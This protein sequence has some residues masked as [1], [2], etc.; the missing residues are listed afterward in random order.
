ML[1]YVCRAVVLFSTGVLF[2]LVFRIHQIQHNYNFQPYS[3][4]ISSISHHLSAFWW[5]STACGIAAAIVGLLYPCVDKRFCQQSCNPFP[6]EWTTVLRCIAIY[7]GISHAITKLHFTSHGELIVTL[8]AM[9]AAL[10]WLCD[11]TKKGLGLGLSS[12]LLGVI[13]ARIAAEGGLYKCNETDLIYIHT[14]LPCLLFTGG[15]TVGNIGLQLA[16]ED[17][18]S[19]KEHSS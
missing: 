14:W 9:S 18:N 1:A 11:R 17:T 10:W 6:Q 8:A 13:I 3:S 19:M 2:T 16:V 7:V 15:I 4:S 5:L 12:A